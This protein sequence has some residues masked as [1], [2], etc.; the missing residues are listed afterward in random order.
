MHWPHLHQLIKLDSRL[1][2]LDI[3]NETRPHIRKSRQFHLRDL[4]LLACV[5]HQN[6]NV[7]H[8]IT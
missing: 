6:R 8:A 3:T 7:F 4:L 5:L 1:I 2:I